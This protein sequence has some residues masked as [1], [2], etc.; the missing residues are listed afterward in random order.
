[1]NETRKSLLTKSQKIYCIPNPIDTKLFRPLEHS[2]RKEFGL[3]ENKKLL[4]FGA[5]NVTDAQKGIKYLIESLLFLQ[6]ERPQ[7]HKDI[8]LV[9]F[10]QAKSDI[11]NFFNVPIH[12]MGYLRDTEQIVKL[13]NTVDLFVTSSLEENLPNTIMES[14]ACGT[15]CVGFQIG[16]IPEMID[17]KENGYICKYKDA[18]DLANG[19]SWVINHPEPGK[20]SESC[21]HKVRSHYAEEIVAKQYIDLYHSLLKE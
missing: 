3:P 18:E 21:I 17:H 7:I 5:L 13:Y 4:L 14:M 12:P 10:G 9:V 6:E 19:I 15:P 2:F 8:E 16:G 11:R 1:V 20:L